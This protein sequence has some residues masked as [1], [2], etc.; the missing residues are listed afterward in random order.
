MDTNSDQ[1]R[2]QFNSFMDAIDGFIATSRSQDR[3][4]AD[5]HKLMLGLMD[6]F[7][8]FKHGN[9]CDWMAICKALR[10]LAHLSS[11][12]PLYKPFSGKFWKFHDYIE[13]EA[14]LSRKDKQQGSHGVPC[15]NMKTG[16]IYIGKI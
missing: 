6:E 4:H 5:A 16:L 12:T 9:K 2:Q 7:G 3:I 11:L 1:Y 10:K 14:G 15:M 8:K 13:K